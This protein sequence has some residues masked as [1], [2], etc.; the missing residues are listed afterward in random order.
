MLLVNADLKLL[1]SFVVVVGWA[2]SRC[3][4]TTPHPI[5]GQGGSIFLV[6]YFM[7]VVKPAILIIMA[8]LRYNHTPI[9]RLP[10]RFRIQTGIITEFPI[11]RYVR[12]LSVYIET[13]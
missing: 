1:C 8:V 2:I 10:C 3:F 4:S 7:I 13:Q 6:H 12:C 5:E 9:Y 11:S